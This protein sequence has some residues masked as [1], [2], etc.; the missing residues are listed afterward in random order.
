LSYFVNNTT[1]GNSDNICAAKHR[2]PTDDRKQD[3]GPDLD[4]ASS[5]RHCEPTILTNKSPTTAEDVG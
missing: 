5:Y 1:I 4:G 2:D 3:G